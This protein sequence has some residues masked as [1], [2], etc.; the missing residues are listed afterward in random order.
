MQLL[1]SLR[2]RNFIAVP[3][4]FMEVGKINKACDLHR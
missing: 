1:A 3:T 2:Q 4:Q